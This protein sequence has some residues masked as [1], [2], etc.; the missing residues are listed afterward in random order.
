MEEIG[1][2]EQEEKGRREEKESDWKRKS[3][4]Y[5]VHGWKEKRNMLKI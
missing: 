4:I 2:H 1:K 5:R 3:W